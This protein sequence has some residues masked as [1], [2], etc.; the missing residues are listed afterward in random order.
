MTLVRKKA[1]LIKDKF[2]SAWKLCKAATAK[3]MVGMNNQTI[4]GSASLNTSG[5]IKNCIQPLT[6][7]VMAQNLLVHPARTASLGMEDFSLVTKH[8]LS[9]VE[10]P[11]KLITSQKSNFNAGTRWNK[12]D[13]LEIRLCFCFVSLLCGCCGFSDLLSFA[14]FFGVKPNLS[15]TKYAYSAQMTLIN[16]DALVPKPNNSGRLTVFTSLDT[17]PAAIVDAIDVTPV[18]EANHRAPCVAVKTDP[19]N[20]QC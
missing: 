5:S 3:I 11:V 14:S 19:I 10:N 8:T 13:A 12:T 4:R 15:A 16:R 7:L 9:N 18:I 20:D 1:P 6:P 17:M 2:G